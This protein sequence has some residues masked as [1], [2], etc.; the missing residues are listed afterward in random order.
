MF[1]KLLP[2][3]SP[4]C[5]VA[6]QLEGRS[7]NLRLAFSTVATQQQAMGAAAA[8]ATAAAAAATAA[9]MCWAKLLRYEA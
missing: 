1:L 8:T 3:I 4:T 2:H 5:S 9:A 7:S 6:Q